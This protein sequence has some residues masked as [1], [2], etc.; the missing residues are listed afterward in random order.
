VEEEKGKKCLT[1]GQGSWKQKNTEIRC[2]RC[3]RRCR[4]KQKR[5]GRWGKGVRRKRK[6]HGKFRP[7][8]GAAQYPCRPRDEPAKGEALGKRQDI[9]AMHPVLT[10]RN[11][12]SSPRFSKIPGIRKTMERK[13]ERDRT[14]RRG[15]RGSAQRGKKIAGVQ[16]KKPRL[17]RRETFL[18]TERVRLCRAKW[19]ERCK[20][21]GGILKALK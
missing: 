18:K 15:G 19:G 9:Q 1:T 3:S 16:R 10:A 17:R 21:R 12:R 14:T 8:G 11:A 6:R 20:G 5:A 2:R 7:E 13:L 4:R